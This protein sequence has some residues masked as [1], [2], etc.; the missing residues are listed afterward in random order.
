MNR[1]GEVWRAGQT[2]HQHRPR[3]GK[4]RGFLSRENVPCAAGNGGGES[5]RNDDFRIRREI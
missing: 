3:I 4:Q 2:L 1:Y 5:S